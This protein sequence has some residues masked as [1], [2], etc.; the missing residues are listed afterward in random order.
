MCFQI[1]FQLAIIAHPLGV[2]CN[3]NF[4]FV[5]ASHG[6]VRNPTLSALN[7]HDRDVKVPSTLLEGIMALRAGK[8]PPA[9]GENTRHQLRSLARHFPCTGAQNE[10]RTRPRGRRRVARTRS[11]PTRFPV[12]SRSPLAV[13]QCVFAGVGKQPQIRQHFVARALPNNAG[14]RLPA[15]I[16]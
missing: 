3:D 2:T 14:A 6:Q 1:S 11:L 16:A 10:A 8:L 13:H 4:F 9:G 15:T 7:R 12:M 5:K